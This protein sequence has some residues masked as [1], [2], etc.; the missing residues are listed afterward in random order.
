MCKPKPVVT[1]AYFKEA[2]A[3]DDVDG[4]VE[5]TVESEVILSRKG[6]YTVTYSAT[7]KSGNTASK[8]CT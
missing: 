7:D 4:R 8:S 1:I 5:M 3:E 2:Y 6:K